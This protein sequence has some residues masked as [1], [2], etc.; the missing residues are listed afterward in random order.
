MTRTSTFFKYLPNCHVSRKLCHASGGN[1]LT[2]L[3][4]KI[5]HSHVSN[6]QSVHNY[7]VSQPWWCCCIFDFCT[8]TEQNGSR[9]HEKSR[10]ARLLLPPT[11]PQRSQGEKLPQKYVFYRTT[12]CLY[13][14]IAIHSIGAEN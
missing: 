4:R 10:S 8:F 9:P 11:T 7:Y 2:L 3:E 12:H 5:L 6:A 14:C 1:S 13:R